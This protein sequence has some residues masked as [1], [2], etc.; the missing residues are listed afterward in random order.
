MESECKICGEKNV[1][2]K[3]FIYRHKINQRAYYLKY[4]PR[5][6]LYDQQPIEFKDKDQYFKTYFNSKNN[7]INWLRQVDHQVAYDFVKERFAQRIQDKK[8]VYAPSHVELRSIHNL[9][10]MVVIN[11]IIGDYYTFISDNFKNVKNRFS[12]RRISDLTHAPAQEIAIDTREQTPLEFKNSKTKLMKL[13][14]GD[15]TSLDNFQN[16]FID[17]KSPSDFISTFTMHY[18]RFAAELE[19][20]A[21]FNAYIVV[22]VEY[23]LNKM[24]IFNKTHLG[25]YVKSSPQRLFHN[26]RDLLQ[27]HQNVQM[28]FVADR[29][30]AARYAVKIFEYGKHVRDIDLQYFYD[31][32]VF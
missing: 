26:V 19:R 23:P 8:L 20:A 6:D 15:Y 14:Y 3:H 11:K 7:M 25:F 16:V 12:L 30:E 1:S 31:T 4:Y 9:P 5:F 21:K 17:R 24:Q 22:L 13:D 27:S 10:N 29:D 28:L 2:E 18:H 32:A